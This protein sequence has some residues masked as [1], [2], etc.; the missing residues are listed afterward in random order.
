[1]PSQNMF[2]TFFFFLI[3]L[4]RFRLTGSFDKQPVPLLHLVPGMPLDLSLHG[5]SLR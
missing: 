2:S 1:M 5:D 4:D 3:R